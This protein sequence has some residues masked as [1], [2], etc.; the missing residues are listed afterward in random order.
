V[1]T[2]IF[3]LALLSACPAH[4]ADVRRSA[5][6][7]FVYEAPHALPRVEYNPSEAGERVAIVHLDT[8]ISTETAAVFGVLVGS[9]IGA[10]EIVVEINTFGGD[11]AA[12]LDIITAMAGA[13]AP[14]TCIVTGAAFSAGFVVLQGCPVRIMDNDAALMMHKAKWRYPAHDIGEELVRIRAMEKFNR[15]FAALA[16]AR[17]KPAFEDCYKK[18]FDG[19]WYMNADEAF[20]VG[21]VDRVIASAQAYEELRRY[22]QIELEGF[23][24]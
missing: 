16:C 13:P 19:D 10:K 3:I 17:L 22:P 6:P 1:K 15:E 2:L 23:L 9:L 14:V 18:F 7:D 20:S 4:D 11:T 5:P 8:S 24:P 21:A 12:A